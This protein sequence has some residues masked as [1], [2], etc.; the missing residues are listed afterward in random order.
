MDGI[1]R[2]PEAI[3]FAAGSISGA[4]RPMRTG[5]DTMFRGLVF[6]KVVSGLRARGGEWAEVADRSIVNYYADA[7]LMTVEL[8]GF[9]MPPI[10]ATDAEHAAAFDAWV[11]LLTPELG[12]WIGAI[13]RV[14]AP[15]NDPALLPPTM[16]TDE[17][18]VDTPTSESSI[19]ASGTDA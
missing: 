17:K 19:E 9:I 2:D 8:S 11:G 10:S 3:A 14:N 4:V 5:R 1:V 13:D 12:A 18:K 6:R 7:A 15:T 16:L